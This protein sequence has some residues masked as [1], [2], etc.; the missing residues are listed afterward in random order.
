MSKLYLFNYNNY[1]NRLFKRETSLANYGTPI[2]TLDNTNFNYGDGV[3][4]Y[5]DVNYTGNDGDY[6]II[7]DG[8][9]TI[10]HRWFVIDDKKNRGGQ[11]RLVLHR[12]LRVDYYELIKNAP[13]IMHRGWLQ[14][15]S[16]LLFN[17][18]GFS[19]NQI[20]KDEILLKDNSQIPWYVV[21]FAKNAAT[22][23]DVS[24]GIGSSDRLIVDTVNSPIDESIY[25]NGATERFSNINY[26]INAQQYGS[27]GYRPTIKEKISASG[28]SSTYSEDRIN[29]D[30]IWFDDAGST[31]Q[32]ALDT[33]FSNK[34][35][36]IHTLDT[37]HT[38][39][40]G[41]DA[42][43]SKLLA[44]NGG[45]IKDSQ[46]KVY[47][48]TVSKVT[49]T[50]T[51]YTLNQNV[52]DYMKGRINA[53]SLT[54]HGSSDWG[55]E[56][57][58]ITYDKETYV[59]NAVL[60]TTST[61]Q[62]T[63]DFANKQQSNDGTFNVITFPAGNAMTATSSGDFIMSNDIAEKFISSL[64]H[65]YGS[66]IYDI[67]LLPYCPIIRAM[68]AW[69]DDYE[70]PVFLGYKSDPSQHV[71]NKEIYEYHPTGASSYSSCLLFYY[72]KDTTF[73]FNINQ[74]LALQDYSSD[75]SIN[76]KVNNEC[77]LYRL[78]SPNYNGQFEFSVAKNNGVSYFNV[79]VTLRPF[80][81][82]IHINPN[83]KNIYGSDFD[84]SRGLICQ[85]D[86]SIPM[87]TD[88]FVEYELQ[89]KNYLNIF[90]RQIE[91]M[92]FNFSMQKTEA[93]VNMIA[94]SVTG[95]ATGATAGA[96]AGGGIP[97]AIAGGIVGGTTS[98]VGGIMDYQLMGKKYAEQKD[99][100]IDNFNYQLG[101]IKALPYSISKVTPYTANNKIW[102]FVERYSATNEEVLMLIN[103]L[104]Y[105]SFTVETISTIQEH[106]NARPLNSTRFVQGTFI[107][108]E[109][110]N[111]SNHEVEV[112]AQEFE[113]GVYI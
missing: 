23:T 109:G 51:E 33:E 61:L 59:V 9:G 89:N 113:K 5:H 67:Q 74:A 2:Y 90:N 45:Y 81:P 34:Y 36:A 86:F 41:I 68:D 3:D 104:T 1:F 6:V 84:D 49:E 44:A 38:N 10:Q 26:L 15:N 13:M 73:T 58:G 76:I 12:D 88:K 54:R 30:Y 18:E 50:K 48:I 101:N 69:E 4:T 28:A 56:A 107:R 16:S 108:I 75:D 19:F 11:R 80:N 53:T 37:E 95:T 17:P 70:M 52:T 100:T 97:G 32:I 106:I 7:T 62:W 47:K 63:I 94:G 39:P 35:S 99:Y 31:I 25:A 110:V 43:I 65:E 82:Y 77:D 20:K 105:S 22:K 102:P 14:K 64:I 91:N 29:Y 92:D 8:N 98:L 42:A 66:S 57:F 78:C 27:Y 72:I 60:D 40:A 93:L 24:F 21:Y 79:D 55:D 87:L 103:R 85:G 46:N 83:F 112:L 71:E 111:A 96:V